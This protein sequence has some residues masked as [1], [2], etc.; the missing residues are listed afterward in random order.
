MHTLNLGEL[1]QTLQETELVANARGAIFK[2]NACD[3]PNAAFMRVL[4][5]GWQQLVNDAS[6]RG[7]TDDERIA[8]AK[9]R[10]ADLLSG[11][12]TKRRS[13][14]DPEADYWRKAVLQLVKN[15][16]EGKAI[17]KAEGDARMQLIEDWAKA[18]ET[19]V[20]R[21]VKRIK[22]VE[23]VMSGERDEDLGIAL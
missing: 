6:I 23:A 22:A 15:K 20:V 8:F 5:Y 14:G 17:A 19:D 3:L 16:P 18:H 21:Q 4:T 13:S 11:V 7:K 9:A 2:I 1:S 10:V 12:L